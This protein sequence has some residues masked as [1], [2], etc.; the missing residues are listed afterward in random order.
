[1]F[2]E[3]VASRPEVCTR[4]TRSTESG[5]IARTNEPLILIVDD[6][7]E[8]REF[9]ATILRSEGYRVSRAR[10]GIEAL[11]KAVQL[12]PSVIVTDLCLPRLD[13]SS[14]IRWLK[15]HPRTQH[16]PIVAVT[17]FSENE[18][19]NCRAKDAC[20]AFFEK[21]LPVIAFLASIKQ[22]TS[23]AGT[24]GLARAENYL[25]LLT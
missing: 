21:P 16:I 5:F 18:E 17:G 13:G 2:R 22:L 11:D 7:R 6:D 14:V 10:D 1:M 12:N 19:A 23:V 25:L 8:L 9:M 3:L 4:E 15:A 20:D 24:K